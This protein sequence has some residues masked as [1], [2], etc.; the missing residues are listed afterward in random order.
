VSASMV[1]SEGSP[2]ITNSQLLFM[3][4]LDC[5]SICFIYVL[6]PS[7]YKDANHIEGGPL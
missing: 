5:P 6:I 7:F 3:S 1:S 2:Y 4:S